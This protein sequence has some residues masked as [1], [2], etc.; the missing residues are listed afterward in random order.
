[1]VQAWYQGG[2]SILDFTD[3]SA[4]F[5][6]AYFDRGPL[7]DDE[8]FTGGYWSAYWYNGRIYGAEISRGIDV[9]ELEPSEHLSAAEIEAAK[10][11]ELDE[12]NAQLQPRFEWPSAVPVARAYLVQ[13]TRSGRILED[14][15]AQVTRVLDSIEG[16]TASAASIA[17]V[18]NALEAGRGG[19]ARRYGGRGC[20]QAGSPG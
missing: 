4:P 13:L 3:P 19:C 8:L 11:V 16:G 9:F 2:I 12:F 7:S 1:M 18:A 17:E 14:R 5:E 10:L 6:I 20:G 15:A